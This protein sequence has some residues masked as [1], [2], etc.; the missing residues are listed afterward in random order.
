VP[1]RLRE[2]ERT[3]VVTGY[4]ASID[5]EAVGPRSKPWFRHDCVRK[6]A[7]PARFEQ[8]SPGYRTWCWPSASSEPRL[9]SCA[10]SPPTQRLRHPR[11][12]ISRLTARR[13]APGLH[14]RDEA[15]RRIVHFPSMPT[16]RRCA[17]ADPA[18]RSPGFGQVDTGQRYVDDRPCLEPRHRPGSRTARRWRIIGAEAGLAAR[19]LTLAMA[20][21]HPTRPRT[22]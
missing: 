4:R 10:W 19:A 13:P 1:P 11:G 20:R 16:N 12:R 2:L 14:A 7:T 9:T 6:T 21:T 18:Q 8:P 15:R 3:R 5:P 22:S 17:S